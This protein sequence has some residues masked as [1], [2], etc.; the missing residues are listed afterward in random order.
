MIMF[1]PR[2]A[3]FKAIAAPMPRLDPV[4]IFFYLSVM[5]PRDSLTFHT[6][7]DFARQF[8]VCRHLRRLVYK[9]AGVLGC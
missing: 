7:S 8:F 5:W 4:T 3:S 2:W 1:A 9:T 6:Y